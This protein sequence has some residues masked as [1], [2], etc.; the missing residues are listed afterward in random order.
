MWS[1]EE[2]VNVN[3]TEEGRGQDSR[4][5]AECL[6]VLETAVN[7]GNAV[8]G[9]Q[10][11]R[12]ETYRFRLRATSTLWLVLTMSSVLLCGFFAD[13]QTNNNSVLLNHGEPG[14]GQLFCLDEIKKVAQDGP[15][16]ILFIDELHVLV[17][18]QGA[19]G[20]G[21]DAVHLVKL[22]HVHR[23]VPCSPTL[24]GVREKYEVHR[25]EQR[26]DYPYPQSAR[27]CE[28][29]TT[30]PMMLNDEMDYYSLE[31]ALPNMTENAGGD[32]SDASFVLPRQPALC[33]KSNQSTDSANY[34]PRTISYPI[35][36]DGSSE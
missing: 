35:T 8:R 2:V 28:H 30:S 4:R 1:S 27:P 5:W 17:D 20:I 18:G 23:E 26:P 11:V 15:S 19:K 10:P 16:V 31:F 9:S 34:S 3:N 22:L 32:G 7:N 14:V 12:N 6:D 24:R 21:M 29:G 33:S 36:L 13:G 25:A